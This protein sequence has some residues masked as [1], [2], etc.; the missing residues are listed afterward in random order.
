ME[1][2]SEVSLQEAEEKD[3][4]MLFVWVNDPVVRRNAFQSAHIPFERHREWFRKVLEDNTVRQYILYHRQIPVGQIRL[5]IENG[6]GFID[7]SI[8][9]EMRGFGFGGLA[10][11]LIKD[12]T[13][14]E[15]TDVTKLVGQVK[16]ENI[17]SIKAF[18]GC[19]YMRTE[20]EA[21]IEFSLELNTDST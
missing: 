1:V 12:K 16:Y 15:I 21:Y 2:L 19:G 14:I 20:K 17:A 9:P 3:C 8:A 10:L 6:V 11:K 18:E 5:N 4:E 13:K 7:Y